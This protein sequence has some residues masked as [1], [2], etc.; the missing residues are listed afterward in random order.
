MWSGLD[1][2]T[3]SSM[4]ASISWTDS[5]ASAASS[6]AV[7]R[8]ESAFR[9]EEVESPEILSASAT[10]CWSSVCC[11]RSTCASRAS[12]AVVNE[13]ALHAVC[14]DLRSER[15][16]LDFCPCLNK[17][18]AVCLWRSVSASCASAEPRT[19]SAMLISRADAP[20]F[21][22]LGRMPNRAW[23]TL[24]DETPAGAAT[25]RSWSS[26]ACRG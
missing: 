10:D 6:A 17:H 14:F 12:A 23:L 21:P 24:L 5:A 22:T 16:A 26:F 9:Q 25:A 19:L 20:S 7:S 1:E 11:S 13:A 2:E 4:A 8:L 18:T 3:T 15:S